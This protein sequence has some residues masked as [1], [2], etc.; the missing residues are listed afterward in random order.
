[1]FCAASTPD[2]R[3]ILSG[4][5]DRGVQFWEFNTGTAHLCLLAHQKSGTYNG[6]QLNSRHDTHS[7][8]VIRVATSQ[9]RDIFAT[10]S[11]DGLARIWRYKR[12]FD[13]KD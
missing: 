10:A 4:S 3:W 6:S 1:V 13:P 7:S 11:G 2:G 8:T 9:N 12:Y 5:K